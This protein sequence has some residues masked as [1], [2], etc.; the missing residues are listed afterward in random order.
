MDQITSPI[1]LRLLDEWQRD[2]PLHPRPFARIS[3]ALDCSEADVLACLQYQSERGRISRVGAT[4]APNTISASTLAS[5]AAP[6]DRVEE[7]ARVIGAQPGINHS[8]LREDDWNLWF[9]ATGPDRAHVDGVL[10]EI[11][12]QTGLRVLDVPLLRPFNIDLGFPLLGGRKRAVIHRPACPE[13]IGAGDRELLQMLTA[14]MPLVER[15]YRQIAARLG[16]TEAH[17]IDRIAALLE[18]G[19]IARLGIIL[20]HRALGWNSNA[21]VV[22]QVAP[23]HIEPAGLALAAHPG[24]TLCYE[25]RPDPVLWPYRLYSMIHAKSRHDAR[26]ILKEAARLPQ[27]QGIPH[28]VLFSSRCFKQ[29][30]ALIAANKEAAA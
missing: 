13:A 27:L 11:T 28:R 3:D 5:V 20:H 25:R 22:W 19:I 6:L 21:M 15:P 30:G 16:R 9:V 23:E 17:V 29:T 1:D 2:F 24:V 4:C 18:A 14:G 26:A 8:Y 12:R 7:T 10:A